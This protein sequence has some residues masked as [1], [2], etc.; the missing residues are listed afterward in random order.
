MEENQTPERPKRTGRT[1]GTVA[2]VLAVAAI[3]SLPV[4]AWFNLRKELKAYAPVSAPESLYIGAGHKSADTFE[5]IRYLYFDGIDA[6]DDTGYSDYV[7][8][9]YGQFVSGF[10]LQLAYTTNNQFSYE[11]YM[12]QESEVS[13]EGAVRYVT[14]TATPETYYYSVSGPMIEGTFLN[15]TVVDGLEIADGSYHNDTYG[16]YTELDRFAEPLYWQTANVIPGNIRGEF[17]HYFI[18]RVRTNEK[19]A[20]DRETDVLCIAAR[21]FTVT[22]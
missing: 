16:E 12:A 5:D 11:L 14:H 6:T 18:L 4:L 13:S 17:V 20:N 15:R 10:R 2:F 7:F 8:C 9:V 22:P 21:S 1:V 19:T 3:L